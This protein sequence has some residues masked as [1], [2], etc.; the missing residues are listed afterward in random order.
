MEHVTSGCGRLSCSLSL[1]LWN[2]LLPLRKSTFEMEFFS[3]LIERHTRQ[4]GNAV[5]ELVKMFGGNYVFKR[6][7]FNT[8]GIELRR[9]AAT[10]TDRLAGG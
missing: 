9:Q 7:E 3:F 2:P 4:S 10:T 5:S 6:N 1:S 8:S